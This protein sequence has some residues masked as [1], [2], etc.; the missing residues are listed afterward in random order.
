MLHFLDPLRELNILSVLLRLVLAALCGGAIGLERSR[1]HRPA[2][3][4]STE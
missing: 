3:W 2:I 1:K 4:N